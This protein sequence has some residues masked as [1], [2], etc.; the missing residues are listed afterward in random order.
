MIL[1]FVVNMTEY[2]KMWHQ[3][4]INLLQLYAWINNFCCF[5][6]IGHM[7]V[8]GVS[9]AARPSWDWATFRVLLTLL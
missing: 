2:D 3:Y 1:K 4:I 9:F 7:N 8:E 5:T 6:E